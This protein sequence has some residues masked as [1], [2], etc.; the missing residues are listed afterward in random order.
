M[1]S[2]PQSHLEASGVDDGPDAPFMVTDSVC[3][4]QQALTRTGER[5]VV[6]PTTNIELLRPVNIRIGA[7]AVFASGRAARP[8]ARAFV[9]F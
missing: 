3:L 7:R 9:E 1:V 8:S 5:N 2:D 4:S 6:V